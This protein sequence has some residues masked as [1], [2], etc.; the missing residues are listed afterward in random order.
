MDELSTSGPSAVVESFDG[1]REE[2]ELDPAELGLRRAGPAVIQGGE[3]PVNAAIARDVLAGEDSPRRD[4]VLLNAAAGLRAAGAAASW[5]D[6][7]AA[8]AAAID[9]GRAARVLAR[10]AEVSRSLVPA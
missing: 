1:G 6:G 2:Y 7:I 4:I 10:W 8:A 3:A 9:D 5:Q